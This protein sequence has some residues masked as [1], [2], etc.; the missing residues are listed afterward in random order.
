VL[1]YLRLEEL[2]DRLARIRA[3]ERVTDAE[4]EGLR[5]RVKASQKRLT[6]AQKGLREARVRLREVLLSSAAAHRSAADR[7]RSL[8]RVFEARRHDRAADVH[9][10][11]ARRL[12]VG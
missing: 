2:T 12:D 4:L 9:E 8:R 5:A 1:A 3:G 11:R 10:E 6:E 7:A